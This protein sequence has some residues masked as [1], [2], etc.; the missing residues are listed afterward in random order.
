MS[1]PSILKS[2]VIRSQIT[3]TMP[4][5]VVL[6][7]FQIFVKICTMPLKA[8]VT[9]PP[10]TAQ[11]ACRPLAM[12]F[13]TVVTTFLIPF[14]IVENTACRL[15]NAAVAA[16]VM[17]AHAVCRP[18]AMAVVTVF[19]AVWMPFHAFV[20]ASCIAVIVF[21]M[22]LTMASHA[23]CTPLLIP[24]HAAERPACMAASTLCTVETAVETAPLMPS[25]SPIQKLRN[26]SDL[27]QRVTNP[28]TSATMPATTSTNGCLAN[29]PNSPE[30]APLTFATVET[31][32][33][34]AFS[35]PPMLDVRLPI[36]ISTG[37]STATIRPIVR[38]TF[39]AVSSRLLNFCTS[40]DTACIICVM[41]G[42]SVPIKSI[43]AFFA[44]FSALA[45][46][47]LVVSV[48]F[49]NASSVALLQSCIWVSISL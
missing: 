48:T 13:A 25:H 20:I 10:M 29:R 36:N 9:P 3:S 15:L 24:S 1:L 30:T 41:L 17:P 37:P 40:P 45:N 12:P 21:C 19:T 42:S 7:T 26:A 2:P 28:A 43:R 33:G 6:M 18:V 38:M 39:F 31:I 27:F 8:V 4:S 35:I 47:W 23:V 44:S 49:W 5:T 34:A 32:S 46:F 14:Q 11:T 16:L 22:V